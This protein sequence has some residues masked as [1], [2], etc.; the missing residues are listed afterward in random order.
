MR[1]LPR[2][3]PLLQGRGRSP[4]TRARP[5]RPQKCALL[6][7]DLG[8]VVHSVARSQGEL[9][10][11]VGTWRGGRWQHALPLVHRRACPGPPLPGHV[12]E[13]ADGPRPEPHLGAAPAAPERSRLLRPPLTARWSRGPCGAPE[14]KGTGRGSCRATRRGEQSRP[15]GAPRQ[16]R[17]GVGRR[18]AHQGP[19]TGLWLS[20]APALA[21]L[22]ETPRRHHALWPVP[23]RPLERRAGPASPQVFGVSGPCGGVCPP[24]SGSSRS[25]AVGEEPGQTSSFFCRRASSI[26]W[27]RPRY[28]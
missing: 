26:S 28:F 23:L 6:G 20:S 4:D 24:S 1:R 12:R 17:G 22:L 9:H 10:G 14:R 27:L 19:D 25:R 7:P 15:A 2:A 5:P 8:N 18:G 16:Q 21:C 11:D 3:R 13:K